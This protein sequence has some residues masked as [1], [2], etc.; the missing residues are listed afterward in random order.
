MYIKH[1]KSL[2]KILHGIYQNSDHHFIFLN[3]KQRKEKHL[4]SLY[5]PRQVTKIIKAVDS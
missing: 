1:F 2:Y 4:Q 3:E 5:D